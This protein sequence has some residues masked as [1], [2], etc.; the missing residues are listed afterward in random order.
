MDWPAWRCKG[1]WP[2]G[3]QVLCCDVSIYSRLAQVSFVFFASINYNLLKTI[4]EVIPL[5]S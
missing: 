1:E 5:L 2:M 4:S 3:V